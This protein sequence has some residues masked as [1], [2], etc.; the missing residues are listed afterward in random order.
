MEQLRKQLLTAASISLAVYL[1]MYVTGAIYWS[2]FDTGIPKLQV[3]IAACAELLRWIGLIFATGAL[4]T[5][6]LIVRDSEMYGPADEPV[7]GD[8]EA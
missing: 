6:I 3:F 8:L 2:T 5:H 7:D 1:L 4:M